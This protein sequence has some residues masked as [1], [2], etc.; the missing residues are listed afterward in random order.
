MRDGGLQDAHTTG[1]VPAGAALIGSAVDIA[2]MGD[3]K[4]QHQQLIVL[5]VADHPVVAHAVA[6][7]PRAVRGQPLAALPGVL[8]L[9]QQAV[10]DRSRV[11]AVERSSFLNCRRAVSEIRRVQAKLCHHVVEA[12]GRL[13]S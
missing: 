4:H 10:Q 8:S 12:V 6:P 3:L 7:E 9:E 13:L 5:D 1:I 2:A 11:W